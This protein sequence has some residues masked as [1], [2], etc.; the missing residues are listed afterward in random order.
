MVWTCNYCTH[1]GKIHPKVFKKKGHYDQHLRQSSCGRKQ[2]EAIKKGDENICVIIDD[3]D[4]PPLAHPVPRARARALQST[5]VDFESNQANSGDI[6]EVDDDAGPPLAGDDDNIGASDTEFGENKADSAESEDEEVET[7]PDT[8]PDV[9]ILGHFQAYCNTMPKVVESFSQEMK[10]AIELVDILRKK[11]ATMD[12]F[13]ELLHWQ[14]RWSKEL[15]PWQTL[16]DHPHANSRKVFMEMLLK[17]YDLHKMMPKMKKVYL[18]GVKTTINV[19]IHDIRAVLRS[20]LSDPRIVT[21]DYLFFDNNPFA[22]PPESLNYLEDL[23]TGL[24]YTETYKKLI[25]KPNQ[26]LL[27]IPLY[28]DASQ[29]GALK[30][31]PVTPVKMTFGIFNRKARDKSHMWRILGYIPKVSEQ[32][33]HGKE[34][35][36]QS[37]HLESLS[38]RE[39]LLEAAFEDQNWDGEQNL[40]ERYPANEEDAEIDAQDLH[41]I[42]CVILSGLVEIQKKGF[43]WDL[44]VGDKLYENVEFVPF[45]PFIKCDS[46]EADKLCGHYCSR[47]ANVSNLCRYC[48]CPTDKSDDPLIDI[49]LKEAERINRLIKQQ[50]LVELKKISQHA[51]QNA[52]NKIRFGLHD[53]QGIHGATPLEMLHFLLLGIFLYTRNC[54]FAQLG[55]TAIL[56]GKINAL[57]DQYGLFFRRQSDRDMPRTKFGNGIQK[58]KKNGKEYSGVLLIMAAILRSTLGQ[59][60]LQDK[61]NFKT[62]QQLADWIMLV[63]TLLEWE[64]WLKSPKMKRSDVVRAKKKHKLIMYM[65]KEVGNRLEGMEW[66]LTKF[67]CILHIAEDLLKYGVALEVDTGSNESHHKDS[68]VAAKMTQKNCETFI[69]QTATRLVE[70]MAIDFALAE[71]LGLKIW[72]YYFGPLEFDD[73][74]GNP[75]DVPGNPHDVPGDNNADSRKQHPASAVNHNKLGESDMETDQNEE[76]TVVDGQ[77]SNEESEFPPSITSGARIRVYK[78]PTT[79]KNCYEW[80]KSASG[81]EQ[82]IVDTSVLAFLVGL[83]EKVKHFY[84]ELIILTQHKRYILNEQGKFDPVTFRAHPLFMG[85]PWRDWALFDWGAKYGTLPGHIWF[86]VDLRKLPER[87]GRLGEYGGIPLQKGIY[88][89]VES[90]NYVRNEAE[91]TKSDLFIPFTTEMK[92][93]PTTG[94]FQRDFYLANVDAIDAPCT[95]IPDIGGELN[96]YFRM[97]PR[98]EWSKLFEQWLQAPHKLDDVITPKQNA[99][100]SNQNSNKDSGKREKS[101][102]DKPSTSQAKRNSNNTSARSKGKTTNKTRAVTN[103][104]RKVTNNNQNGTKKT[105]T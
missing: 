15:Y 49:T 101:N 84:P 8:G 6:M 12:S 19:P 55:K 26:V 65:L 51:I 17:R 44:V 102:R 63:E 69:M 57:A 62:E 78:C 97:Q 61:E 7:P 22:T 50:N 41:V 2:N 27:P 43:M 42:L 100:N 37:G 25:T 29:T 67:H 31:L 35:L 89:V 24:C 10:K 80:T 40:D 30:E 4:V 86:F 76:N 83:Q 5:H 11:K 71:E 79:N 91:R 46:E 94:K 103:N 16:S 60:L 64:A 70:F 59:E 9:T 72:E 52:F 47:T 56:A 90:G 73:V 33:T 66:K 87:A 74:S 58:G 14:L 92:V 13:D 77:D 48:T 105:K 20:L 39:D 18:P 75:H 23:N 38:Y 34:L 93:D 32:K 85:H 1:R 88:C 68:K 36:L 82:A 98:K 95:V 28:I 96:S 45:V 3:I 53:K 54:F 21:E 81:R 104:K 99:D